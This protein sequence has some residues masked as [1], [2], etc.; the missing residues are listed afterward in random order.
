MFSLSIFYEG[1]NAPKSAAGFPSQSAILGGFRGTFEVW[2]IR[3]R[4]LFHRYNS[5][6]L[7]PAVC[8]KDKVLRLELMRWM[9]RQSQSL[10]L[11]FCF[12]LSR[13]AEPSGAI[14]PTCS[15]AASNLLYD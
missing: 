14:S 2:E 6:L 10:C 11:H 3:H 12:A 15:D 4:C 1:S 8:G 7:L 9:R 13:E 5:L